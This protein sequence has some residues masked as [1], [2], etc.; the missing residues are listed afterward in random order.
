MK[1]KNV[2]LLSLVCLA[3]GLMSTGSLFGQAATA[4]ISGTVTDSSAAAVPGASVEIR[5]TGT[6]AVRA[7]VT[8]SQGRYNVPDLGIGTYEV[9]GSKPGFQTI[10]RSGI[11]LTVG[12]APVM[13]LQLAVGQAQETVTV[14]A[15]AA[16]VETNNSAVSSLV[17]QTQM[18]ELPLNGRDFEQLIL[19]APGVST[20][21]AGGS[22][23]LTSV[24]NAF[25]ISGTRPE[26]YANMLDGESML[27][28]WQRNAGGDVTGT[29]LGIDSIAEFQT[30]TGT[31]GAQYGGNG[32][33]I[34]A[35]SKSGTNSLHG[36]A[37]EF[38][39][40]SALDARGFFDG[41]SP[42]PFRRNQFGASAGGP[43]KKDKVFFFVNYEGIRQV[44]DTTYLN[45]V[46][47][48]AVHQGIVS[49]KQYTVN[50]ASA[51]MLA[52]YPLPTSS[53]SADVGL[54]NYVG[55]QT[56][57]E[58]FGLA[59]VDWNIS[60]SDSLFGR[61]EIDYGNR[62]TYAGLG[63]WPT[64]D[65]THNNFLTVGERH[66][67]SANVTN[68]F[69]SSYSRPVTGETQPTE[70]SALQI[71]TPARQDVY[72]AMPN[73]I[74]ALGSSFINPFQYLQN[75]FTEK[76]DLTWIKG[77][78][79]ISAGLTFRR[80][81][82]NPYAYTYWNGFYIFTSLPNFL[83]GNP[84][85]FTG[86]PNGGTNTY[87]AERLISFEPYIQDDWKVSSRVTLNLG[88]RYGWESNP[89]EIHNNFFNAV[90]P[91]FGTAFQNVP[92]AYT[93]NPSV[94]N[95]D[96]RVGLAW[97]VFGDH[98]TS[99]RAGFGIF[100]DVYQTY[101]FSS[102]YLTNPPVPDD[103]SVLLQQ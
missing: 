29:S 19:L 6:G 35:V 89:V 3:A 20:Y 2:I 50:S 47:S 102:A 43:I 31:Y 13:D 1:T 34:N 79:T 25:S 78:H 69:T 32:G 15:D 40:N 93:S 86:A 54:Y 18:R 9:R 33:A 55:A 68:Q 62:T 52:L 44:L 58:N 24:A 91:P 30:L 97:D 77:S 64:F 10:V 38:F 103:E 7:V 90:G 22:S 37:Y 53:I 83:T 92:H 36:S 76:D 66:I 27:N 81:Q 51:A 67:F 73:G 42:P 94:H 23:A 8:D 12:S 72:I 95:L 99:V 84:L 82:L 88:L 71:F 59:R 5:N 63:L 17:N 41:G 14:Q 11:T 85:S 100:H 49:G 56:S 60:A 45:F 61:W 65:V 96:P 28:W 98:K 16:Q 21:P 39:R 26:G 70:H 4:S 80:E 48:A 46:P 101:T 75:K 57:P 74:G 87:R